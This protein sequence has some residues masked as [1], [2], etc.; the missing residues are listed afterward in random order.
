LFKIITLL[1]A[2]TQG[3]NM[4][5]IKVTT[6]NDSGAGSLRTAVSVAKAGDKIVFAANLA[7]QTITLTTGDIDIKKNLTIDASAASNLTISGNNQSRIFSITDNSNV[8][9]K[10]L[11]FADGRAVVEGDGVG[12]GGAI[13]VQRKS[14][15]TVENS[16]FINNSAERSG[17]IEV[18]FACSA[19]VLNST[20]DGNDG[21]L[22]NDPF[23]AGAISTYGAGGTNGSGKVVIKGSTFTNNKG[24]NGGAVYVL[25]GPLTIENSTFKNNQSLRSGGAVFTDGASGG[26]RDALG[27]ITTISGS[28][29]EGNRA[30]G[31]GGALYLWGYANDQYIIKDS[32]LIGNSV[33]RG[34]PYNN[35][36]GGAIEQSGGSL[37]IDSTTLAQNIAPG[38]GGGLWV[39]NN[40]ASFKLT[41]STI[42]G[43]TAQQD[44]G[45]G[46]FLLIPDGKPVVITNTTFVDNLAGRDAGAIWTGRFTQN[47]TIKNSLFAGNKATQTRQNNTNFQFNDGG[48]NFVEILAGDKGVKVTAS[49]SYVSSLGLGALQKIGNDLVHPLLQSSVAINGGVS[50]APTVDQRGITRD[51]APDAGAYEYSAAQAFADTNL[52]VK[53]NAGNNQLLG[54]A[55]N[56]T[57]FGRGGDDYLMGGIGQDTL[58]GGA[59]KDRFDLTTTLTGGFDILVDFNVL[60]DQILVSRSEFGLSQAADTLLDSS[61][62]RLGS[63]AITVNDRFI[64]DGQTGQLFFDQDGLGGVNQVQIATLS[65]KAALG[66]SNFMVVV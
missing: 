51:A 6:A 64:Y 2:V 56:D 43:N 39:N 45:G 37:T 30:V 24:V 59:G 46:L 4:A 19:T 7:N 22:D 9:I 63:S 36:R 14:N 21:T 53:G 3:A 17:A 57:L 62:F 1:T 38:Q 54:G 61:L 44:A 55:G 5:I 16:T 33:T 12:A 52:V 41:N 34:G 28:R 29:F 49:A 60:D 18:G 15:L 32:T 26:A 47:M 8:S 48:G 58:S 11:T 66:S 65:N 42:S 40:T 27:G 23:S 31:G 10:G 35:A 25:L 13:N 20:F 50:G